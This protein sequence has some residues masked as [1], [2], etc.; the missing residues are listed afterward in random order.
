MNCFQVLD[1]KV[2]PNYPYRDDALLMHDAIKTYVTTIVKHYYGTEYLS[3]RLRGRSKLS[4]FMKAYR[5]YARGEGLETTE[6][7][8]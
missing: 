1:P 2:L 8:F 4:T 5:G 6:H 7:F 3:Y